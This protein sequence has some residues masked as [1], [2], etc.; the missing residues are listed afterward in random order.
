VLLMSALPATP[1]S[2]TIELT[3]ARRD[4]LTRRVRLLV[5][6]TIA[7]NIIESVVAIT[8]GTSAS[9]SSL[10]GFGFD[11]VI[12]V[13]SAAAVAWQ[14][15]ARD[16]GRREAREHV[17]LR[18]TACAF[19]A[20]A[21]F[22]TIDSVRSLLGADRASESTIGIALAAFSLL[23]MPMLSAAQR[24]AGRSLGS[25][26]AV[27]DSKQTLLCTYLSAVLLAG[28]SANAAFGWWWADPAAGLVIAVLAVK[29]GRDAWRGEGCCAPN[30]G[31]LSEA[32]PGPTPAGC[33]CAD[34]CGCC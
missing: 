5:G 11:S 25:G 29:E 3:P 32:H 30:G 2:L 15:S 16:H 8:A 24:R 27:A 10:L 1:V 31:L 33:D 6:A 4:V 20:L 26:S 13:S 34:G 14:F 9:S 21:V 22:V 12:E 7:Y 18:V 17:A 23:I 28:L 19:F